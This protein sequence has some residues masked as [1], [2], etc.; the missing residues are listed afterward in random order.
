MKNDNHTRHI[1]FERF[2]TPKNIQKGDLLGDG[3]LI[4][5]KNRQ[6]KKFL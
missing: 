6:K 2:V 1:Y 4:Y 3:E 5:V